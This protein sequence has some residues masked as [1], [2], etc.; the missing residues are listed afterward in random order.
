MTSRRIYCRCGAWWTGETFGHCT[1]SASASVQLAPWD[2]DTLLTPNAYTELHQR[3]VDSGRVPAQLLADL[4]R[5]EAGLIQPSRLSPPLD[6]LV[7]TSML[8]SS[9]WSQV[10]WVIVG[11]H[12]I[13]VMNMLVVD[14]TT[15]GH[16]MLVGLDVL[17]RPDTPTKPD[18]TVRADVPARFIF[19]HLLAGAQLSDTT[20]VPAGTALPVKPFLRGAGH[21]STA[22]FAGL[23]DSDSH[24][25]TLHVRAMCHR[26]FTRGAFD[27]HQRIH[28]GRVTCSTRGLVSYQKLWGLLWS[29]PADERAHQFRR[30]QKRMG[31]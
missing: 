15:S 25:L 1:G 9:E 22:G 3:P 24:V 7:H 27:P 28:K 19:R 16:P 8:G 4:V 10:R 23:D 14:D 18:V 31:R 2:G 21:R 13:D 29:L 11:P 6:R 26:T 12:E 20:V 5:A 17:T 30:Q